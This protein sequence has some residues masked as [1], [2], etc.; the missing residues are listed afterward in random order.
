MARRTP[1]QWVYKTVRPPTEATQKEA[2]DPI[3]QLNELGTAGRWGGG[4]HVDII[5]RLFG[6]SDRPLQTYAC[7]SKQ[8]LYSPSD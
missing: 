3:E 6:H 1:G 7:K 5:G 8:H 2:A 4:K